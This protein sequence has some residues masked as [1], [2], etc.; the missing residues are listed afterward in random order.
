[1]S[2]ISKEEAILGRLA[3]AHKAWREGRPPPPSREE[4]AALLARARAER[5]SPEPQDVEIIRTA[6]D[7]PLRAAIWSQLSVVGWML[8]AKGGADMLT[9]VYRRV[10]RDQHPGFAYAVQRAWKDLGFPGDPRGVWSGVAL[11]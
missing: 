7:D 8:Y 9:A 1:M 3:Q 11:L 2:D 4:A 10:E 6:Q 5:E